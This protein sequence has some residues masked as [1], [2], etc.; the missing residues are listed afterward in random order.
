MGVRELQTGDQQVP[1]L[2]KRAIEEP[3]GGDHKQGS[4]DPWI[5][6][7]GARHRLLLYAGGRDDR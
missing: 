5:P 3:Q 7:R 1:A 2:K 6:V 4:C